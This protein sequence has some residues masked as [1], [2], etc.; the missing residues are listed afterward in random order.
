M[1]FHEDRGRTVLSIPL[2]EFFL[3]TCVNNACRGGNVYRERRLFMKA[4]KQNRCLV[5]L[6]A[7]FLLLA[8]NCAM[9]DILGAHHHHHPRRPRP[10]KIIWVLY[11]KL[12]SARRNNPQPNSSGSQKP[13][14]PTPRGR[15]PEE[16]LMQMR[17]IHLDN[18]WKR[19]HGG[20]YMNRLE[21]LKRRMLLI[22]GKRLFC[23]FCG[24]RKID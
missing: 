15:F 17:L 4:M 9:A 19:L 16:P 24:V 20:S 22:F 6:T 11:E 7:C 5:L 13:E 21:W 1:F 8:T 14:A 23:K 2:G 10:D 3:R 18:K 12:A